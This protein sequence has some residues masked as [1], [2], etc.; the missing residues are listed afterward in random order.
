MKRSLSITLL[1]AVLESCTPKAN[2]PPS[3]PLQVGDLPVDSS[4][5]AFKICNTE[6]IFQYYNFGQGLQYEGE[7]I[8]INKYFAERFQSS[9]DEDTGYLTIR[10][11][12]NCE[13][14]TGNFRL[15][16][17]SEQYE[18]KEFSR[19]LC[20]QLLSLTK[21]MR[22]WKIARDEGGNPYDYYQYLT[23]K[24]KQGQLIEILP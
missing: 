7:K 20:D 13:G 24:L 8:E 11:V 16:S 23:F 9:G 15:E 2:Q 12:V 17:M 21:E 18:P 4:S 5:A 19:P 6:K 3:Y 22:G 1:L 14:A 10:F